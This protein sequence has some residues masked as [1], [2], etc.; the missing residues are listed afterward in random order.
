VK[1]RGSA[2]PDRILVAP[3]PASEK[4]PLNWEEEAAS[5]EVKWRILVKGSQIMSCDKT[6]GDSIRKIMP[7]CMVMRPVQSPVF[8]RIVQSP[9]FRRRVQSPVFRRQVQSPVF[10]RQVQSPVFRLALLALLFISALAAPAASWA[11]PTVSNVRASQRGD[12][13]GLVDVYYDLSGADGPTTVSVVFSADNGATWGVTPGASFLSGDVGAGMSNGTDRR[14]VWNAGADRPGIH[15]TQTKAQVKAV[16]G[17]AGAQETTINLPGGVPLVLVRVPSGS[18]QMGRYSGERSSYASEDPQHTV[19]IGYS[20]DMGKTELTQKQ[21]LAVM[22]SWPGTA[23]SSTYGLGD[24][25]PAY[26]ISWN[27]CQSFVTVLNDYITSTGQGSA[28]FRLPSEAEWEYACRAGTQTRSFFGDSLG[29]DDNATDAP[30]SGPLPGNRSDYMW[31]GFNNGAYGTP[32]YG[33]KPVG[34]KLP[35]QFGLY[36]MSGNMYEWCEDYW[37]ADYTGAPSNGSAWLSPTSLFR[38]L[39][40]GSW[41]GDALR[42]RSAYR[43][44]RIPV[45]RLISIGA[46][47]VRTQ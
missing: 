4:N 31:F 12:G 14:V 27:D 42:C 35:N 30:T 17:S 9:V 46:R 7:I 43:Y 3:E 22:G 15:W 36:D 44:G 38:L 1:D 29:A 11:A 33:S 39:R 16:D 26:Y 25:Y 23:P 2:R 41:N 45:D 37:H 18:F 20:F 5:L 47:F 21:W 34:T 24:N 28:T 32:S 6:L 13:S 19:N 8:R 10:R 40:G